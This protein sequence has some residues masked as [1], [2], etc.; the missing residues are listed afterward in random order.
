MYGAKSKLK[1][2]WHEVK[3]LWKVKHKQQ[4]RRECKQ[5]NNYCSVI[6]DEITGKLGLFTMDTKS[7]RQ[8]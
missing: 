2:L 5:F 8:Y 3:S 6:A 7:P 1:H 4:K